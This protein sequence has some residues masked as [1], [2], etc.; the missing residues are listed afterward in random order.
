MNPER[1][2]EYM[3][4]SMNRALARFQW[5]RDQWLEMAA[6]I[7]L[8]HHGHEQTHLWRQC[9]QPTCRKFLEI[10]KNQHFGAPEEVPAKISGALKSAIDAHGPIRNEIIPSA[11]KRIVGALT[12]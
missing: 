9:K 6:Y 3:N 8:V 4:D 2:L 10:V 11:T 5:W 7:H 1:E 12:Q